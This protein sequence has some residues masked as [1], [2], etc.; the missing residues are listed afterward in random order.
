MLRAA[1]ASAR[2][3]MLKAVRAQ[4]AALTCEDVCPWNDTTRCAV[5]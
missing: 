2:E 1:R 4:E 3:S 5:Y